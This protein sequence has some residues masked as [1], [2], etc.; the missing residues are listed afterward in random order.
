MS[1][2]LPPADSCEG[3]IIQEIAKRRAHG[4][5]KYGTTVERIDLTR[6]DWLQHAK[7]EALDFA[8]YLER[9]I[10]LEESGGWISVKDKL[11]EAGQLVIA[12]YEGIY[13]PRVVTYWFDGTHHHFGKPASEPATHWRKFKL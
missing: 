9:L 8:V 6:K 1:I 12:K 5:A 4:L 3:R 11:P 7:E 2:E 10:K 13:E